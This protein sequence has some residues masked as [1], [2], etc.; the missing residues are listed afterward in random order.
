MFSSCRPPPPAV[1]PRAPTSNLRI[2]DLPVDL[3][4]EQLVEVFGAYGRIKQYKL[5]ASG[6]LKPSAVVKYESIDES[7][8]IRDNLDG[9]IPQGLAEPVKVRYTELDPDSVQEGDDGNA[10]WCACQSPFDGVVQT[11]D[12]RAPDT[13]RHAQGKIL[14]AQPALQDPPA[15]SYTGSYTGSSVRAAVLRFTVKAAQGCPC[16]YLKERSTERMPAMFFLDSDAKRFVVKFGEDLARVAIAC[17]TTSIVDIYC[18]E[19]DGEESFPTTVMSLLDPQE[20]DRL[21]MIVFLM[22]KGEQEKKI[23]FCVLADTKDDR[24]SCM[25]YLPLLAMFVHSEEPR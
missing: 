1:E 17:Y 14:K 7:K 8:W 9:N 13:P 6:S 19:R 24:D 2:Q 25:R 20:Y 22:K 21:F 12:V 23:R 10:A 18:V 11:I 3:T 5:L 16:H 15:E 4:N